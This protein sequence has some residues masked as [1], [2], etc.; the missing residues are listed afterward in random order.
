M[1]QEYA[2]WTID[3]YLE[4]VFIP[5]RESDWKNPPAAARSYRA[6]VKTFI[7][8][9]GDQTKIGELTEAVLKEFG[10]SLI[11]SGT[12]AATAE[13]RCTHLR[14]IA[15]EVNPA[16]FALRVGIKRAGTFLDKKERERDQQAE[17]IDESS[18]TMLTPIADAR[19]L[20]HAMKGH[21]TKTRARYNGAFNHWDRIIGTN[22]VGSLTDGNFA[23]Y[24]ETRQADG[25]ASDTIKGELNK[26]LAFARW[27][28]KRTALAEPECKSPPKS[29]KAP[30]AWNK[31]EVRRLFKEARITNRS[32]YGMPGSVY[33]PALLYTAWDTAERI[34]ALLELERDDVDLHQRF[35]RL[36]HRKGHG[37]ELVKKITP[38]TCKALGLLFRTMPGHTK[39]FLYGCPSTLWKSYG[40]ILEDAGLP[41]GRD[42]KFHRIR[43]THATW[44]HRAGGDAT[45]SLGHSTDEVTRANYLDPR[46][47]QEKTADEL[48]FRPEKAGFTGAVAASVAGLLSWFGR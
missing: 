30:K 37:R 32:I 18:T 16:E 1:N 43:K 36:S 46:Y 10:E 2:N 4:E 29:R 12:S 26:I 41:S 9:A 5:P 28:V 45:E 24:V 19:C 6:S 21:I 48:L 22:M 39:V 11:D 38:E 33:W 20:Y 3:R 27:C 23:K 8:Y 14:A 25:V 13:V 40:R 47:S 35:I 7:D 42:S 44:L 17:L 34:G 31:Q 15:R